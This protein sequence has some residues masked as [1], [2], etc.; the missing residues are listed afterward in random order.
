MTGQTRTNSYVSTSPVPDGEWLYITVGNYPLKSRKTFFDDGHG[1][2]PVTRDGQV[3]STRDTRI[4][5]AQECESKLPLSFC[6][7][8]L[9]IQTNKPLYRL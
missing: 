4:R 2:S 7:N 6:L 9:K 3:I 5:K 1:A 8:R